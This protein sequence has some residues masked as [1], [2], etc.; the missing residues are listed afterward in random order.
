MLNSTKFF[1]SS[2]NTLSV[3]SSNSMAA[4]TPKANSR[5]IKRINNSF[6]PTMVFCTPVSV[7]STIIPAAESNVPA[8]TPTVVPV[9]AAYTRRR[10]GIMIEEPK[11]IKKKD[12]VELDE[13][14][15]RRLHEESNKD[16]DWDTAIEHMK[17]KSKEDQN[18]VGFRLD[19]FKGMSYDDIRLIFESKFN[20][21]IEF[22]LKS[23]EQMEEEE[24]R[25]FKSINET[26]WS[27]VKERFS[28]SKPNNYSDDYLLT[29]LRAMFG[30]PDGQDNIS[31]S[32][33][34]VHGQAMVKS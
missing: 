14:Y 12:Q 30:R 34:S 17:Q 6:N 7:V 31:K 28:T 33:R 8:A 21:N 10:K 4:S 13:E 29:T 5:K 11:P 1:T 9:M 16:I 19:Y 22:L 27:I 24:N 25:A 26:P 2:I 15:A 23:K 32:Q 3:F 20:K 18:T